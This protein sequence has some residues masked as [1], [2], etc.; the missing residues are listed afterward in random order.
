M[1]VFVTHCLLIKVVWSGVNH[2]VRVGTYRGSVQT[3]AV[4]SVGGG[5]GGVYWPSPPVPLSL[6]IPPPRPH[7]AAARHLH[8]QPIKNTVT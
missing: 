7:T 8:L 5:H 6:E 1:N 2:T 3:P 4:P